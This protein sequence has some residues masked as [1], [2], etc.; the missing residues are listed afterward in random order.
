MEIELISDF[1]I[2]IS[3]SGIQV[4]DI[5]N[6]CDITALIFRINSTIQVNDFNLDICRNWCESHNHKTVFRDLFK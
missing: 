3:Q 1:K 2:I 4:L 6:N 5:I